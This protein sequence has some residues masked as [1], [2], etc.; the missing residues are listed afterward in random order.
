M[1]KV[2]IGIVLMAGLTFGA[3][4][5]CAQCTAVDQQTGEVVSQN[6]ICGSDQEIQAYEEDC[7]SQYSVVGANCT[8]Q[9]Q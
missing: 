8:C 7:Q 3:C 6:D 1:R 9:Y 2:I 4:Q 5:K